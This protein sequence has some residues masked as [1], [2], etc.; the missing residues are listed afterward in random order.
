MIGVKYWVGWALVVLPSPSTDIPSSI[1]LCQRVPKK[2]TTFAKQ[3]MAISVFIMYPITFPLHNVLF[4]QYVF[5]PTEQAETYLKIYV[6]IYRST[7][8]CLNLFSWKE[9]LIFKETV[10]FKL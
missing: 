2:V 7:Y 4:V 10:I 9:N 8:I 5:L 3:N 1:L 6:L